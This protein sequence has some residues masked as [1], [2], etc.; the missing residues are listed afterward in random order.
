MLTFF[1]PVI[2]NRAAELKRSLSSS[3]LPIDL[4][5]RRV[6]LQSDVDTSISLSIS[7]RTDS[8]SY[9]IEEKSRL[10][11]GFPDSKSLHRCYRFP[12]RSKRIELVRQPSFL[13][14][15]NGGWSVGLHQSNR[16]HKWHLDDWIL[17]RRLLHFGH[18]HSCCSTVL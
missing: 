8:V 15:S 11:L 1:Y 16:R 2:Y 7:R 9:L 14:Q 5:Y 12:D 6:K 13:L 3:I 17:N 4:E 10:S 18:R